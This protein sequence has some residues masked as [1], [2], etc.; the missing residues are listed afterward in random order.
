MHLQKRNGSNRLA[1]AAAKDMNCERKAASV[2]ACKSTSLLTNILPA[3]RHCAAVPKPY[4]VS[5]SK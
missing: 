5:N 2:V 3:Q 1:N 4:S